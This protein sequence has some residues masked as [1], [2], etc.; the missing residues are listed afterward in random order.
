M[1]RIR[2]FTPSVTNQEGKPQA[3]GE[4][5][6]GNDRLGFLVDLSHWTQADYE[7][8]WHQGVVRLAHG[9]P[10]TALMTAWR[11]PDS[12]APHLMYALWR[13]DKFVYAQELSVLQSDLDGP[14]DPAM[15]WDHVGERIPAAEQGLPIVELR[16]DL[17]TMLGAHFFP[18][19]PWHLNWGQWGN[20]A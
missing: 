18:S 19:F 20:A 5:L 10:C 17:I 11:G 12:D 16:C 2:F 3:G 6:L 15:P 13:D 9:A 14:F 7:R 1:F 8:Q 4:L